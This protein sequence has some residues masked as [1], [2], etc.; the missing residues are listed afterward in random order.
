MEMRNNR[1][2]STL[3]RIDG[4]FLANL[5]QVVNG[6]FGAIFPIS[7]RGPVGATN[8]KF[9]QLSEEWWGVVTCCFRYSSP[10]T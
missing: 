10:P 8:V 2:N 1:N 9:L 7:H 5:V 4:E 3:H 6:D